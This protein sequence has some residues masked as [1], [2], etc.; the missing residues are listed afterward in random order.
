[1]SRATAARSTRARFGGS[2][3]S[4]I[5]LLSDWLFNSNYGSTV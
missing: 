1:M 5:T 2:E 4:H 3:R